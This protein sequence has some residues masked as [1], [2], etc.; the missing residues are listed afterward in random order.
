[1]SP[2]DAHS[3]PGVGLYLTFTVGADAAEGSVASLT[4]TQQVQG[5]DKDK[6]LNLWYYMLGEQVSQKMIGFVLTL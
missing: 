1:M 3:S 5:S 6:C 2:G 4:T